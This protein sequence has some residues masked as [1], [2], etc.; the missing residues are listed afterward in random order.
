MRN[1]LGIKNCVIIDNDSAVQHSLKGLFESIG[2]PKI[3]VF[4][5]GLLAWNWL[6]THPEP[7]LIVQE[8]RIPGLAGPV[9]IQR[10]RQ[11][12]FIQVPI[13]IISSLIQPNEIPLV[14]EMG[15]DN[16]IEKPFDNPTFFGGIFWTLQQNRNPTDQKSMERK[17]RKLLDAGK[18]AEAEKNIGQLVANPSVSVGSKRQI[19]AEYN[20]HLGNYKKARDLA[21]VAL[22]IK[23][24]SLILMNLLGKCFVK[25]KNFD[26]SLKCF[27][28][29]NVVSPMNLGRLLNMAEAQLNTGQTGQAKETVKKIKGIDEGCKK[30]DETECK[31]ALEAGET[32]K[33][34]QLMAKVESSNKLIAYMNNKAV[35]LIKMGK[36]AEGIELYN[37]TIESVPS[38]W[39][40]V[41]NNVTYNLGLA[42]TRL[43]EYQLA[44]ETFNK[45]KANRSSGLFSKCESLKGRIDKSAKTGDKLILAE[46]SNQDIEEKMEEANGA[47]GVATNEKGK[48]RSINELLAAIE[49]KR[50]DICCYLIYRDV[51]DV[52]PNRDKLVNNMPQF[53]ERK[54][55]E[56]FGKRKK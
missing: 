29:A 4:S 53:H 36:Y 50:G 37:R 46:E 3:E 56:K 55:I 49:T 34:Q 19:E 2:V 7:Q 13:I 10:I 28:K 8:W 16:V 47:D 22:K 12:G 52:T 18:I 25:L 26:M 21:L 38:Q 41:L 9:L 48:G 17:I 42:Y 40:D 5:N 30:V 43:G 54:T 6:I 15:V 39:V 51:E 35:A 32:Q 45:I 44:K 33:A 27:E 20:Y 23:G 11:H 1:I 14:K 31:I 24:D